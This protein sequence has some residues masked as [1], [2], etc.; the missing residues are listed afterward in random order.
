MEKSIFFELLENKYTGL[1]KSEKSVGDYVLE[2]PQISLDLSI[3]EL[4]RNSNVSEATVNRFCRSLGYSGYSQMKIALSQQLA[5]G[6][7]R[8][9]PKDIKEDDEVDS[10]SEKLN[11][12]LKSAI[13]NTYNIINTSEIKLAV[14]SIQKAERVYFYGIGGSGSVAK[15]AHHLFLKAGIINYYYDDGYM[16]VVS[17]ATLHKRD[18][19]IGISHSGNTKDIV[20]ALRIAKEKGADTIAITGIK[21]SAIVKEADICLF[22]YSKEDPIYGDFMEAKVSQIYIIDLLYINMVLKNVPS[23]KAYLDETARVVWNRSY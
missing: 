15:I 10:V 18:L 16:Q 14:N 11:Y 21:D 6:T 17:A 9:I 1:R 22:T 8:N 2:N 13:E 12:S 4:A 20:E 7:I 3:T 19:A 5:Q 23:T